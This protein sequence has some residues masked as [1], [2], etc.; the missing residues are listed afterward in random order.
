MDDTL[1]D[2]NGKIPEDFNPVLAH[3]VQNKIQMVIASGRPYHTLKPIFGSKAGQLSYICDNGAFVVHRNKILVKSLL[4]KKVVDEILEASRTRPNN[5]T[6]LCALDS[7]YI[8]N[9]EARIYDF[10]KKYYTNLTV[11][12]SLTGLDKEVDKITIYNQTD[13]L[14]N[15]N[16]LF[17]PK[18]GS[19]LYVIN[20]GNF[21]I[22]I[23]NLGI[24]KGT[25]IKKIMEADQISSA[26][27][28]AFG[29]YYN[30]IEMLQAAAYSFVMANA[31]EAMKQYG[32][33]KAQSNR[34][35]GVLQAIREYGL[36]TN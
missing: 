22:D 27:V 15:L 5:L 16:L 25:G 31:P 4:D 34:E 6:I 8:E 33:Y 7:A 1:L 36:A 3:L 24:N 10:L 28:M 13:T 2:E 11:V 29:D 26:E 35:H 19:F 17:K 32:K 18:F 14:D 30:D 21:W 12:D 23:A 20:S 9:K